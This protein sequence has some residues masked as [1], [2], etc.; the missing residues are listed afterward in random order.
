MEMKRRRGGRKSTLITLC[1]EA[2]DEEKGILLKVQGKSKVE[3]YSSWM[4]RKTPLYELMLDYTQRIGVPFNSLRL[5]YDGSAINP[6][7]TPN[8]L[9]MEDAWRNH[10]CHTMPRFGAQG[11]NSI[12][13]HLS[14]FGE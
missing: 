3:N 2:N 7:L 9:K 1:D 5:L 6:S 12:H 4:G 14:A 11:C 8:R 10:R 13:S